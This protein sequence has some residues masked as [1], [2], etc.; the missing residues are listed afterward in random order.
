MREFILKCVVITV[1][2]VTV[3]KCLNID[4]KPCFNNTTTLAKENYSTKKEHVKEYMLIDE[5]TRFEKT[6]GTLEYYVDWSHSPF[7]VAA[8]TYYG[9]WVDTVNLHAS[10]KK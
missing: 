4:I 8:K 7:E 9:G 5:K 10:G 6:T 1:C 2:C 3:C